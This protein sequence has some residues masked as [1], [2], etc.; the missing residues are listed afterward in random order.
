MD[1]LLINGPNLNALGTRNPTQYGTTTLADV[2]ESVIAQGREIG[3]EVECFQSNHEGGI[4]D[5]IHE[6][7]KQGCMGFVINPGAYTH[8]SIAI[9]DAFEATELPFVEIHI[10]NVHAREPFR[11]H[12]YLSPIAAGVIVGCGVRGYNLALSHLAALIEERSA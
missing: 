3:L 12:S 8:T 4:V 1:V 10:S 11:Q 7:K 2:E 5:R 6:A 9:R